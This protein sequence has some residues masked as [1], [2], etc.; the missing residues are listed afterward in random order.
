M[1]RPPTL[2]V[3]EP[4]RKVPLAP[5]RLRY[6][7]KVMR[8]LAGN[9]DA[10]LDREVIDIYEN[11]FIEPLDPGGLPAL[12]E[13]AEAVIESPASQTAAVKML[14]R[15]CCVDSARGLMKTIRR[16]HLQVSDKDV[17]RALIELFGLAG[18]PDRNLTG[19]DSRG[20]RAGKLLGYANG[21]EGLR[22]ASRKLGGKDV[23]LTALIK[24]AL[25]AQ[26][27]TVA[28]TVEFHY[29][30]KYAPPVP[31]AGL[32]QSYAN[33]PLYLSLLES[34]YLH[35]ADT[36]VRKLVAYIEEQAE[37]SPRNRTANPIAETISSEFPGLPEGAEKVI[38]TLSMNLFGELL[39]IYDTSYNLQA[40]GNIQTIAHL[41]HPAG[42]SL[43]WYGCVP[44]VP[45]EDEITEQDEWLLLWIAYHCEGSP[46]YRHGIAELLGLFPPLRGVPRLFREDY[47]SESLG[48]KGA[49]ELRASG[50]PLKILYEF[51]YALTRIATEIEFF[52]D[53]QCKPHRFRICARPADYLAQRGRPFRLMGRIGRWYCTYSD[54]GGMLEFE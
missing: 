26:L 15:G 46:E 2:F 28:A 39:D 1:I 33:L 12:T 47:A 7:P 54:S 35:T 43:N 20:G 5:S 34:M 3:E 38:S 24:R 11:G 40:F 31:R 10:A 23:Y 42:E 51:T 52:T 22:K 16:H 48:C 14:L 45:D 19:D 6:N 18:N 8:L 9:L 36:R 29:T 49:E 13:L 4:S 53:L 44:Y 30:G 27:R 25:I 21:Y 50:L 41:D 32:S 37:L 17:K